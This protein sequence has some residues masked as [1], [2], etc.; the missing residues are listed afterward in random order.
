MSFIQKHLHIGIYGWIQKGNEIL[1]IRKSRGPYKGLL[2]LPGGRPNHG[3]PLLDALT[4]EIHEETA[5]VANKYFFLGNFS[6]LISYKDSEGLQKEL[7][8]IALIYKVTHFDSKGYNSSIID[9]DVNGSLWINR[10]DIG[11]ENSSPLV[12]TALENCRKIKE[13]NLVLF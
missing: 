2:D 8:H 7:Y 6:F 11:K 13:N 12:R 5:I 3:E 1:V 10:D 4:R 9:E